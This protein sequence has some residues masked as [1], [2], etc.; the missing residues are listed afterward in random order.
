MRR[1][2]EEAPQEVA[3]LVARCTIAEP[4]ARPDAAEVADVIQ[5]FLRAGSLARG[6]SRASTDAG[7]SP[8][9]QRGGSGAGSVASP[10][11]QRAGSGGMG[12][13][14][15]F[16]ALPRAGSNAS[17]PRSAG[18][19]SGAPHSRGSLPP[20]PPSPPGFAEAAA[21]EKPPASAKATPA[22]GATPQD[23]PAADAPPHSNPPAVINWGDN[24][25]PPGMVQPG[26]G[27]PA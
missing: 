13:L 27:G 8:H 6:G 7:A 25:Q 12:G 5:S 3:D 17:A 24:W 26:S 14:N 9:L 16:A 23:A 15:G 4:D 20:P 11:P 1:V 2:P 10:R 18:G 19:S 21:A 22:Q